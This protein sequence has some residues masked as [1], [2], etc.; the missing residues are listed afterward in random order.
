MFALDTIS[1][2]QKFLFGRGG[3]E[4]V[5]YICICLLFVFSLGLTVVNSL[6]SKRVLLAAVIGGVVAGSG[7]EGFQN[8]VPSR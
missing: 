1:C 4:F 7:F 3:L 2:L 6:V 5:V 8:F